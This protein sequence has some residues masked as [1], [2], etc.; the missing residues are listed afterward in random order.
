MAHFAFIVRNREAY[1]VRMLIEHVVLIYVLTLSGNKL[2][3]VVRATV[4]VVSSLPKSLIGI[5]YDTIYVISLLV[6][7]MQSHA[8]CYIVVFLH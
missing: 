1:S 5:R 4:I 7:N 8:S 6:K 2:H 3:F